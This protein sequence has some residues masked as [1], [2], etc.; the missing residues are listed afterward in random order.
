MKTY[1]LGTG[2]CVEEA[3]AGRCFNKTHYG[4]IAE[5]LRIRLIGAHSPHAKGR[6]ERLWGTLQDRLPVW[7]ILEGVTD[8]ENANKALPQR[9]CPKKR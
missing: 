7:F 3:L 4:K 2:H 8:I 6:V 1:K 9:Y 5:K